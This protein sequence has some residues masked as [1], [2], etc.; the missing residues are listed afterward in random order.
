MSTDALVAGAMHIAEDNC[1]CIFPHVRSLLSLTSSV[2]PVVEPLI[3]I[4]CQQELL[5]S[6]QWSR[7]GVYVKDKYISTEECLRLL[8]GECAAI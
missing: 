6:D 8:V 1:L 7:N 5:E 2:L 3:E 4:K